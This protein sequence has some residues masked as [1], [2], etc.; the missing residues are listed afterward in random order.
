MPTRTTACLQVTVDGPTVAFANTS[1][2][3]FQPPGSNAPATL[4]LQLSGAPSQLPVTAFL[5]V[6]QRSLSPSGDTEPDGL[7]DFMLAAE[8]VRWEAGHGGSRNITVSWEG[9]A[10]SAMA[11]LS[12]GAVIVTVTNT[13]NADINPLE[14][15]SVVTGVPQTALMYTF[16]LVPNQVRV[17]A[18]AS[19]D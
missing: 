7:Q 10:V 12:A 19:V 18:V 5:E 14:A 1:A 6:S 3:F 16:T 15:A 11:N 2:Y 4:E 13:T 9:F 8:E 17:S